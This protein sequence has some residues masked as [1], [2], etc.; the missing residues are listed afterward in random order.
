MEQN[1]KQS[2]V[3]M[4]MAD[5]GG[6]RRK[7]EAADKHN[8]L[9]VEAFRNY[10]GYMESAEFRR[11]LAELIR[12]AAERRVC[13]MCAETLWWRCHRRMI[14]DALELHGVHVCHLG[15]GKPVGHHL[16][17][18]ARVTPSKHIVYDKK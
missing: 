13:I 18:V 1:F 14:S 7:T 8:A 9:R 3:Y 6:R 5:L 2:P 11:A 12:M 15:M 10:A 4:H 16:W 17:D